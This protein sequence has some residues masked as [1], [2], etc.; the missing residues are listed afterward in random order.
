[1]LLLAVCLVLVAFALAA[2]SLVTQTF[3]FMV[4]ALALAASASA[5]V[6]LVGR[7]E[8]EVIPVAERP[9]ALGSPTVE[10]RLAVDARPRAGVVIPEPSVTRVGGPD[11]AAAPRLRP[12]VAP[13]TIRQHAS[14]LATEQR[15][16]RLA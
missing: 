13:D 8:R 11:A 15:Q 10:A 4:V 6:A 14:R 7:R 1:M 3:A 5:I 16:D 12:I 9:A 2:T